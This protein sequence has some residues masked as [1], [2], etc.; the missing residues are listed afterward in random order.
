MKIVIGIVLVALL[1][2]ALTLYL[3][4]ILNSHDLVFCGDIPQSEGTQMYVTRIYTSDLNANET[5]SQIVNAMNDNE[6]GRI[7]AEDLTE[8]LANYQNII[9]APV[10][11]YN[12]TQEDANTYVL[13]GSV[14]DGLD[15]YG[16][17]TS[18][19]FGYKN[20][21]LTAGVPDGKILAAQ[22]VYSDDEDGDGEPEFV[23]RKSVIEP[24][25]VSNDTG[26]AFTF[27]DCDSFR[28][29]FTG[30]ENIPASVTLAYTYDVIAE[31]PLNFTSLHGGV[32]GVTIT[33]AYDEMG[34]LTPQIVMDRKAV[35][36]EE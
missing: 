18:P 20:L 3:L 22:N 27:K 11:A 8:I 2:A 6:D 12:L 34:R 35:I 13:T 29:V 26:A 14:Y 4:F 19:D 7:T 33:V 15:E 5:L 21:T 32:M 23:E 1:L 16:E 31:N 36:V 30:T 9:Y 25:L 17:P 24:V 28:L 10:F